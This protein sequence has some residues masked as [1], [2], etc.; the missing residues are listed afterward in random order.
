MSMMP[1]CSLSP[2]A[3]LPPSNHTP[4]NNSPT[5]HP[6]TETFTPDTPDKG[7]DWND[8]KDVTQVLYARYRGSSDGTGE[9][10]IEESLERVRWNFLFW[11]LKRGKLGIPVTSNTNR[12][13]T[14]SLL[15]ESQRS[16]EGRVRRD[17]C[18]RGSAWTP[19][20]PCCREGGNYR[21][22]WWMVYFDIK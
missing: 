17:F 20:C 11:L 5:Y 8:Q 14:Q 12:I 10:E 7:Q 13:I 6:S 21:M 18:Y 4:R 16:I 15:V 9:D 1:P 19:W 2:F 22:T 3:I